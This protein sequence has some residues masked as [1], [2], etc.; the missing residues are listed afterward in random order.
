MTR[1][2]VG[3]FDLWGIEMKEKGRKITM[4]LLVAAMILAGVFGFLWHRECSSYAELEQLCLHSAHSAHERF[5]DYHATGSSFSYYYGVAELVSFY[6]SYK[7]LCVETEGSTDTNCLYLNN[8]IGSLMLSQEAPE[9]VSDQL[10]AITALLSEN[11]Y[12][13]NAFDLAFYVH[14]QLSE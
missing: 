13:D 11:I 7:L 9:E 4:I 6:N 5:S 1:F 14:N 10:V 2:L 3:K 8:L 12:D